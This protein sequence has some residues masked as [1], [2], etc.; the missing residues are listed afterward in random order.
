[1]RFI[2][3]VLLVSGDSRTSLASL[4]PL[5]AS[6]SSQGL[7]PLPH[8]SPGLAPLQP[9]S[10]QSFLNSLPK[11]LQHL[12]RFRP[13]RLFQCGR[14][15]NPNRPP[16]WLSAFLTPGPFDTAPALW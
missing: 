8:P 1:M 16:Q 5:Q 7:S 14:A 9:P 4:P 15:L 13:R 6:G 12:H 10:P 3:P 11:D 2:N